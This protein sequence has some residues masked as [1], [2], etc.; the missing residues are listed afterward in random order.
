VRLGV[1]Q[2]GLVEQADRRDRPVEP[3]HRA[4][5]HETS[6]ICQSSYDSPAMDAREL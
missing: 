3:L 1:G 6:R 5:R 2:P 4:D